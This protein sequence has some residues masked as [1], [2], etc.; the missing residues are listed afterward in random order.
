MEVK[1]MM[2]RVVLRRREKTAVKVID[3]VGFE[4]IMGS[5]DGGSSDRNSPVLVSIDYVKTNRNYVNAPSV[6]VGIGRLFGHLTKKKQMRCVN[7]GKVGIETVVW[8]ETCAKK[9]RSEA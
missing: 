2:I 4:L 8:S 5:A 9:H 6:F 1:V 7:I 3:V